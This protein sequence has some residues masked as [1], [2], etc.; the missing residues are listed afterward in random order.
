[1]N[2]PGLLLREGALSEKVIL[3]HSDLLT[4]GEISRVKKFTNFLMDL[5]FTGKSIVIPSFTYS[6][7]RNE[8]FD[9]LRSR[10]KVGALGNILLD[11]GIRT[12]D[13][14]FS[15]LLLGDIDPSYLWNTKK[16]SFG[17]ESIYEAIQGDE[18]G[19]LLVGVDF[20]SLSM[21][22]HYEIELKVPYRYLKEFPGVVRL[23]N[24]IHKV[25]SKHF[26][27]CELCKPQTDRTKLFQIAFEAGV[28]R[29]MK[30]DNKSVVY[31]S[32]AKLFRLVER[33][34][35]KDP[36]IFLNA[37]SPFQHKSAKCG[38]PQSY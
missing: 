3:C 34:F 8:E 28:V 9:P 17:P 12:T 10:S 37:R 21:M 30:F 23:E 2:P 6:A 4:L 5:S 29:Y 15:H 11:K 16:P 38:H 32:G 18:Y 7:F 20:R 19:I 14:N 24:G 1:M 31:V 36:L 22:M 13:P 26:V 33:E 35:R 25:V 27:R